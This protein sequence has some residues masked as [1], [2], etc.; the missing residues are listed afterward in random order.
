MTTVLPPAPVCAPRRV[1]NVLG[2]ARFMT[3]VRA[4]KKLDEGGIS[5]M[6]SVSLGPSSTPSSSSMLGSSSNKSGSSAEIKITEVE[7][8]SDLGLDYR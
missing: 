2:R 3:V 1:R 7:L 8:K 4:D 6:T 5:S